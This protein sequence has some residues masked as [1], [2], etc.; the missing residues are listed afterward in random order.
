M[1][2]HIEP[3]E[4]EIQEDQNPQG[5]TEQGQGPQIQPKT[6]GGVLLQGFHHGNNSIGDTAESLQGVYLGIIAR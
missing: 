1:G 6:C 3:T 5:Y 4:D 2:L